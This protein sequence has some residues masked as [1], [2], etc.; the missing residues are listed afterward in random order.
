MNE[1]I[2]A[3]RTRSEGD[4]G[5]RGVTTEQHLSGVKV[6][7]QHFI[8]FSFLHASYVHSVQHQKEVLIIGLHVAVSSHAH[9]RCAQACVRVCV[10]ERER[11]RE[12]EK[13][14]ERERMWIV[15]VCV[16]ERERERERERDLKRVE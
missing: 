16:C 10:S 13:K 12:R 9:K 2:T 4:T 3:R 11:E 14:R 1:M 6:S 5:D 7:G 8:S 15:C